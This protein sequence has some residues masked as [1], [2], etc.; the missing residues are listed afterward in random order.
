MSNAGKAV[1]G[2]EMV[3]KE[4][5]RLTA[6]QVG[7]LARKASSPGLFPPGSKGVLGIVLL[8]GLAVGVNT[9]GGGVLISHLVV[10][11]VFLD[12]AVDVVVLVVT[13][14]HGP[15]DFH[16]GR[17]SGF[18]NHGRTLYIQARRLTGSLSGEEGAAMQGLRCR[19]PQDSGL[20]VYKG[21]RRPLGDGGQGGGSGGEGGRTA[22]T[23]CTRPPSWHRTK[24]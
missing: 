8:L 22:D 16:L 6:G 5:R 11:V 17:L 10:V 9:I 12:V 18:R 21:G 14:G 4:N 1:P 15:R 20:R 19:L 7:S 23:S 24:G 3:G 2:P 13:V